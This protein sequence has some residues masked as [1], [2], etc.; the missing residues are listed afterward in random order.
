[1]KRFASRQAGFYLLAFSMRVLAAPVNSPDNS[2]TQGSASVS[3]RNGATDPKNPRPAKPSRETRARGP[4]LSLVIGLGVL[5]SAS[6]AYDTRVSIPGVGQLRYSGR[7]RSPALGLFA[8]GALTLPGPLR[9]ITVGAGVNGDGPDSRYGAVIPAGVSTPFSKQSLYS[10]I[11]TRYL[12]RPSWGAAFSPFLE[13]D[14]GF[15]H[16][17]RVRAGYQYWDQLGEYTG[18]FASDDRRSTIS[19]NVKL[20]LRSHLFRISMN[21]YV[22]LQDDTGS[23]QHSKRRSGMIQ[24]WGI[25]IGA[26]QTV[27]IF[28]AIGPSW[29]TAR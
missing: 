9:R 13:H 8:G 4:E 1:V 18:S 29:Q 3:D 2:G 7:Q 12:F 14:I 26:H 15:F 11:Q 21:D 23:S 5:P 25:T 10:D 16:G 22:A 17:S 27:M 20:N 19:Y 24:Q 28:A 6:Y